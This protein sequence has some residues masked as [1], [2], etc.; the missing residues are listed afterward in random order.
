MTAPYNP[1][2]KGNLGRSVAEALLVQ[3]P[4]RIDK[5]E[6]FEGAG[7][8]AIYYV[9]DFKPYEEISARNRDGRFEAPIY[10]GEAVPPGSRKGRMGLDGK[11]NKSLYGRLR[12][13]AGSISKSANLNVEDFYCRYLI[14]DEIWISLGEA[15]LIAQ[16]SPIWNHL[17]D[18]FGNHTPGQRRFQ[19]E[20]SR[21]DTLHPGRDWAEKCQPRNE[22]AAQIKKELSA[23]LKS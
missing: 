11:P 2:E 19:Q 7:I 8:Y 21:W 1:L 17:V 22:T 3:D 5:L 4:V 10:V 15:L 20:R 6:T 12:Q 23:F 16:Y 13:H 9:G 18:G 14:V